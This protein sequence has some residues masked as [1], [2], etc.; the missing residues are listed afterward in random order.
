[1]DLAKNHWKEILFTRETTAWRLKAVKDKLTFPRTSSN[2][3]SK[4]EIIILCGML[5]TIHV[6]GTWFHHL[7]DPSVPSLASAWSYLTWGPC[8]LGSWLQGISGAKVWGIG[9][10]RKPSFPPQS[11]WKHKNK[12]EMIN[13]LKRYVS[14]QSW[15]SSSIYSKN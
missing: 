13:S 12:C 5:I 3:P 14:A 9:K 8:T 15:F 11:S 7:A 6:A 4:P 1:M 2:L 10:E